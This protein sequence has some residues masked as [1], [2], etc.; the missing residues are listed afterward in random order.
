M[1]PIRHVAATTLSAL[2]LGW[3]GFAVVLTAPSAAAEQGATAFTIRSSLDGK[4]V[5]PRRI[6]WIAYPSAPVLF[7]GAEFLIDGKV[8]F[9]NRLT[10]TRSAPTAAT[11]PRER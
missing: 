11:R 3:V 5:L 10:H 7:P 9:A 2:V 1:K 8:V 4:T 6:R